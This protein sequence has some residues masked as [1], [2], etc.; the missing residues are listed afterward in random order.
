MGDRLVVP[1][2][3]LAAALAAARARPRPA[4]R[5]GGAD[6]EEG[7]VSANSDRE[8]RIEA[9]LVDGAWALTDDV[10]VVE[11]LLRGMPVARDR[12]RPDAL[13]A[14][15]EQL[16]GEPVE[17]SEE[18]A[19]RILSATPREAKG[20]SSASPP[21]AEREP[22]QIVPLAEFAAVAEPGAAAI[23][24]TD[25]NALVGEDSD[26]MTY[27]DGGVGKTSLMLDLAFH[28]AAGDDWLGIS[29]P[30]P[31]RVLL[32]ENEGPRP[33]F[34]RKLR[35]KLDAWSGS[36][37]GDRLL[38]YE[39]PWGQFSFA[40]PAWRRLLADEIR[41]R[42][43]D[44]LI[45]GPLTA[46]GMD[47]PGTLQE[48]REFL[49]LVGDVRALSGRRLACLLVHHENRGGKV[50][51]AWEGAGDTL[52]HVQQQG[53]GNVRLYVQ[54]ARWASEQHGTTLQ[55]VWADGEGFALAEGEAARPERTWEDIAAF[56][57]AN[58]GCSWSPVEEGVTGSSP[59]LR[60]RRDS[61]LAEGIL[62]NTGRGQAFELWHR[63]DPARP[64]LDAAASGEGR[65]SDAVAS[66][67]GD[68]ERHRTASPRPSLKRDGGRD[69]VGSGS[70]A[71]PEEDGG[72]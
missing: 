42:E 27:G 34:R 22:I 54:K 29:V 72:R 57:L 51:G 44:V 24:G 14:M 66:T 17:L 21:A 5:G 33:L 8:R 64:T 52:L 28:F 38:V 2:V 58:G 71:E 67:P 46:S 68:E 55:L 63:D 39:K 3:R 20:A 15:G 45:V 30:R 37:V 31:L 12:L 50:S 65:G 43:I 32:I 4:A 1:L 13:V 25:D 7:S 59:Y 56:V 49:A 62:V 36:P 11:A 47:L 60:K 69:A 10:N 23:L 48:C 70:P 18:L 16:Q 9:R 40:D 6:H 26:V 61:M 19:L 35:R 53:R 41:E